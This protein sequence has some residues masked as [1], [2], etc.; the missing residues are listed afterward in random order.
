M[1]NREVLYSSDLNTSGYVDGGCF[2]ETLGLMED[3]T[4][5]T[6][7]KDGRASI[8]PH[9]HTCRWSW[10]YDGILLLE[11]RR[12][13]RIGRMHAH[14]SIRTDVVLSHLDFSTLLYLRESILSNSILL[15]Y[16]TLVSSLLFCADLSLTMTESFQRKLG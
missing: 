1:N 3:I 6:R 12:G 9:S 4:T 13:L 11:L 15:C 8:N 2:G 14:I 5:S 10:Y 7:R 16:R